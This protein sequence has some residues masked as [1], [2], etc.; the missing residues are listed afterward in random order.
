METGEVIALSGGDA[1]VQGAC[2]PCH[3]LSGEGDGMLAP[4]LAGSDPGHFVR[5]MD[6]FPNGQRRHAQMSWIAA[7]LDRR[8][9]LRVADYYAGLPVP[10]NTDTELDADLCR[11]AM[12]YHRGDPQ[13]GIEACSVCHGDAGDGMGHGNPPLAGQPA[14]YL[15]AQLRA[16]RSGERYG[17]PFGTMLG[18]SRLLAESELEY[19]AGYSAAL[20]GASGNP[21]PP[22]ACLPERRS[23]PRNGA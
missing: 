19:L 5:Q 18:I 9:R 17:D 1:G 11:A 8:A 2:V 21:G 20:Q 3:G 10:P 16:W 22:E 14:P 6:N 23:V 4:R 13:R 12:L 7:R 15:A